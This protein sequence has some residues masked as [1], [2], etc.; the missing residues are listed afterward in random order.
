[1]QAFDEVAGVAL[2][3]ERSDVD[4]DAIIPARWLVTVTRRGLGEGLFGGWRYDGAGRPRAA[5]VLNQPAYRNACIIVAGANYG[6]GS[7]REHAVWAHLDYGVRAVIAPSYG[8]IFHENSLNNGLLP[9]ELPAAQVATLLQQLQQRPGAHC[10]VSLRTMEVTGPDGSAY[11]FSMDPARRT[12]L[13]EGLDDIGMTARQL[14]AIE[15]FQA[16]QLQAMPWL[17][18]AP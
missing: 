1:M 9:V 16:R 10:R 2:P 5:F 8:P 4:T 11:G 6:C 15:A 3:L 18:P 13:L 12:A 14:E 17:R 7:S